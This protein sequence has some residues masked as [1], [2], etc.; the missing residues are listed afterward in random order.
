[1]LKACILTQDIDKHR[2]QT[3]HTH[4][5]NATLKEKKRKKKKLCTCI[6]KCKCQHKN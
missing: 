3:K 2:K 6:N 4:F 5:K 1:M